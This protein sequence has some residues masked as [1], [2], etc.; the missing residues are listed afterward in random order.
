[1]SSL[2][3]RTDR[4]FSVWITLGLLIYACGFF[5]APSSKAQYLTLYIGMILPALY[6]TSLHFRRYYLTDGRPLAWIAVATIALY[7]PTLW[8]GSD[9]LD[10]LRKNLKCVIIISSFALAV[11]HLYLHNEKIAHQIPTILFASSCLALLLF[12]VVFATEG[13][14][15]DGNL[16]MG[17][18]G[19][20]PN[21]TGLALSVGLLTGLYLC[22]FQIRWLTLVMAAP[23]LVAIVLANSRAALLGLTMV[24]PFAFLFENNHKRTAVTFLAV[25]ALAGAVIIGLMIHGTLNAEALLSKRPSLWGEFLSHFPDFHWLWGSGLSGSI[26]VFSHVQ[27]VKLEP[28]SLYFSLLLRGGLIALSIFLGLVWAALREHGSNPSSKSIWL[29]ILM[30][31]MITQCFEGVYPVRP[32]NSF[33]LYTWLPLLMLLLTTN[34]PLRH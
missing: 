24:I 26:T 31:G 1:M 2:A 16:G 34:K 4:F 7:L 12:Y 20:N 11:R 15:Q 29:Y 22:R 3:T 8:V 23:F 14:Q 18:L 6:F 21:E 10:T 9:V 32:P 25:C 19:D 30:F 27:G 28:H 5:L 13:L 17:T 33:W